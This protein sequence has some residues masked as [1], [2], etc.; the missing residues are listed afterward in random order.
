MPFTPP[1]KTPNFQYPVGRIA[2]DRYD[3]EAH[4]EGVNPPLANAP[5][6]NFR[7][8]AT[9][10]DLLPDLFIDGYWAYTV[11]EAL[12]LLAGIVSPPTINPA[13]ATSLGIIQLGGDLNGNNSS[14]TAP[15]VSG[16][17]GRPVSSTPPVTGQ[18]LTWNGT[19]WI[20]SNNGIINLLGDVNGT[21][22]ASV[23]VRLQ[24]QPIAS[25][26]PGANQVLQYIGG[27]WTPSNLS[28]VPVN[29]FGDV[30]GSTAD[31]TVVA[32]RGVPLANTAPTNG[33]VLEYNSGTGDWTPTTVSGLFTAG[34]DLSGTATDQTVIGIQG[35]PVK[36]GT[37][38][39]AQDGYVLTWHNATD[40]YEL[41]PSG[42]F[43]AGNDLSG[44]S[45]SQTVIGIQGKAVSNATPT[46][47]QVLEYNGTE[48]IPTTISGSFSAGG[49]LSG[50]STNQTVIGLDTTPL[51][52]NTL[53]TGNVLYYNGTHWVNGPINLA[54]GANYVTGILP[55]A[56]QA[57]Q[58]LAGDVT[59]TTAATIV[60]KISGSTPIPIT[61]AGLQWISTTTSPILSQANTTVT[62]GT[63]TSLTIQAQNATGTGTTTGG[64]LDLNAGTGTT[65]QGVINLKAGSTIQLAISLNLAS[66]TSALQLDNYAAHEIL[67]AQGAS[68]I[69][70]ISPSTAGYV[71]TSNG[72]SA[73][74]TFQPASGSGVVWA[75]DLAGSTNTNQYVAAIS[76]NDNTGGVVPLNITTLRFANN[77]VNPALSQ[78][79]I[80]T[81]NTNGQ[82]LTI[83]A[84]NATGTG[85]STGGNLTLTSGTGTS[86]AG[87]VNL[88]IGGGTQFQITPTQINIST[89]PIYW[90][91]T[92]AFPSL[93]Q[94]GLATTSSGSGANGSS[95]FI[96]SQNGQAATGSGHSGGA[97]SQLTI[98]S[99]TGGNAGTGAATGGAGGL[100]FMEAGNGGTGPTGGVGGGVIIS[101]GGGGSGA[102][103][104]SIELQVGGVNEVQITAPQINITP[105][106]LAWLSSTNS[107]LITQSELATSTSANGIEGQ[108]IT[109][110]SQ[111]GQNATGGSN[112]GGEGGGM[113]LLSGYGGNSGSSTGGLGGFMNVYAGNGGNPTSGTGGI[114]GTMSLGGGYGG[115]GAAGGNVLIQSG[116]GNNGTSTTTAGII[117]LQINATTQVS[118]T[119]LGFAFAQ[120]T[121]S[122]AT[123]G[124]TYTFSATNQL[125]PYIILTELGTI[126][127]EVIIQMNGVT[128]TYFLDF[129]QVASAYAGPD[130][131]TQLRNG[132]GFANLPSIFGADKL[133]F[134]V[135]CANANSIVWG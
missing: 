27:T 119:P 84:Q 24:G 108:Q 123:G 69:T 116:G 12:E 57:P 15:K 21:T 117:E 71:L 33:Q 47:G 68:P 46:T 16:L 112:T 70:S 62:N 28:G 63:G 32:L 59:G 29:I 43:T 107:P 58:T 26:V 118:A 99:G 76:G 40:Q 101:S 18:V 106:N 17:Q 80:A 4:L 45:T 125:T 126:G 44:T 53:T 9:Q 66:F 77:Q 130:I 128:G 54:G 124:E 13:T 37:N 113:L 111:N 100:L 73:D 105:P 103:A 6:Q 5:L 8:N 110:N 92:V 67:V 14:A 122:I 52:I 134:V 19:T 131:A 129:S 55:T 133:L 11:Q 81:A 25:T 20:P 96:G 51:A 50:S 79:V 121:L 41:L 97:G 49:D 1:P 82:T 94:A 78:N 64:N 86:A 7:H 10:V 39:A 65:N 91:N 120:S 93:E 102:A 115:N 2:T 127:A 36:S 83:Q 85:T 56:N 23:V 74:P 88:Q 31:A 135:C 104:G 42:G 72:A 98:T 35:N 22:A 60:S 114:G 89:G 90:T 48:W 109:V 75:D 61:P 95:M 132:S 87:D 3:F 30:T 38:G 34:G